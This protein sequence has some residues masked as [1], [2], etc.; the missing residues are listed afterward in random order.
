MQ[1]LL[2][3]NQAA[4][5]RA[6]INAPASTVRLDVDPAVL[7]EMERAVLAAVLID[8]HD[9]TKLGLQTEPDEI[10]G[11]KY[12]RRGDKIEPYTNG[13]PTSPLVL[14]RPD[15]E[16]LRQA[17]AGM[18]AARDA[19]RA[20][21]AARAVKE[22][23]ET[24]AKFRAL[25]AAE[26]KRETLHFDRSG[27]LNSWQFV[28]A[29]TYPRRETHLSGQM[30]SAVRAE[31][32]AWRDKTEAEN[33]A[34]KAAAIASVQ[35]EI[36]RI[37]E[38]QAAAEKRA[39][40]ERESTIARLPAGFRA[41]IAGGFASKGQ[42]DNAIRKLALTDAGLK[43]ETYECAEKLDTLTDDEFAALTATRER[44]AKDLPGAT[45][46]PVT[47]ADAKGHYRKAT[48]DD[49][50]SEIDKD[51]EVWEEP[52]NERRAMLIKWTRAGVEVAAVARF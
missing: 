6:G 12:Y 7:T 33:T 20:E 44:L 2:N 10:T 48:E 9:A 17:I 25:V 38:E 52:V 26:P 22:A 31:Y 42:V 16:G 34:A 37:R 5:L 43:A 46:E 40:E 14:I 41:R 11:Q 36:A 23:A 35:P 24:E 47:L 3:V 45:V 27:S 28:L 49:D 13:S 15:I 39:A 51:G 8:G 18:L 50:E 4:A 21:R 29:A 30:A 19:M 32:E 1:I